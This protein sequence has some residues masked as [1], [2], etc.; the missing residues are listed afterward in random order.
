MATAGTMS[1]SPRGEARR[2]PPYRLGASYRHE[3]MPREVPRIPC[4]ARPA[5]LVH[6]F[7]PH[8]ALSP[9]RSGDRD[10]VKFLFYRVCFG[11]LDSFL[12]DES[13]KSH[14]Y[15]PPPMAS[16]KEA[17]L[18][19]VGKGD[20]SRTYGLYVAIGPPA[21]LMGGHHLSAHAELLHALQTT[22][23]ARGV[24]AAAA[25]ASGAALVGTD[26][27]SSRP[28][29]L[30]D[31]VE[32]Q[33]EADLTKGSGIRCLV[34]GSPG[35][36]WECK[37]E[38][39]PR[40][41]LDALCASI[42]ALPREGRP[43]VVLVCMPF[44]ARKAAIQLIGA[45]APIVGWIR[46]NPYDVET[47]CSVLFGLVLPLLEALGQPRMRG[48]DPAEC[49]ELLRTLARPVFRE[50][51]QRG[52]V[53]MSTEASLLPLPAK[54]AAATPTA[55]PT[56]AASSEPAVWVHNLATSLPQTS[57]GGGSGGGGGGATLGR[58]REGAD[59]L[60]EAIQLT[61]SDAHGKPI[62]IL[63]IVEAGA[64]RAWL[65]GALPSERGEQLIAALYSDE[66]DETGVPALQARLLIGSVGFLH[67]LR[68]ATLTGELETKLS[69]LPLGD[70]RYSV[71]VD[72]SSFAQSY[73]AS[74]LSLDKLTPHQ[75]EKLQ[76]CLDVR[77]HYLHLDSPAG[78][79]KT[80][81][82]M[83]LAM[84]VLQAGTSSRVCF[85]AR[86][87]ALCFFVARWISKRVQ[88]PL[89]RL[90]LLSRVHV[91]FEPFVAGPRAVRLRHGA[92]SVEPATTT[93]AAHAYDLVVIDEAHH[94]FKDKGLRDAVNRHVQ[95]PS[96]AQR[97]LLLSD[98]SQSHGR[99][100]VYPEG[101]A[102]VVH[103]T[104]VVRSSQR[105]VAGAA[106]FQLGENK[107]QVVCQHNA[108]GPP[109]KSFLC[110]ALVGIEHGACCALRLLRVRIISPS[111]PLSLFVAAL[112]RYL[113]VHADSTP[114]IYCSPMAPPIPWRAQ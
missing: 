76:E 23:L 32:S 68:D 16:L 18:Q 25:A 73:E 37:R 102:K 41:S 84:E 22:L 71:V 63:K 81:V 92:I 48:A 52:G 31:A 57:V 105:I 79:G 66:D 47:A 10:V 98:V 67:E 75:L 85:V 113:H 1:N 29:C 82:A 89:Q 45:G 21:L 62:D 95:P 101:E 94:I 114:Q 60:H 49:T 35:V 103:L 9:V 64:V 104:E 5:R 39:P 34:W 43:A 42:G 27:R 111:L 106:A 15:E 72:R 30:S 56:T 59:E 4:L 109:L 97:L 80:F 7:P 69:S 50:R 19:P 12:P 54:P 13:S 55:T 6:L 78:A 61:M 83:H 100:I 14:G 2:C 99:E 65:G 38:G 88:N 36:G 90:D 44:G 77:H 108:T 3:E 28:V 24:S 11:L 46:E 93:G 112:I 70:A 53:F 86:N 110:V 17:E 40:M 96:P 74:V 58:G 91:L 51:W 20:P 26:P 33:L 107:Q 87:E 8:A